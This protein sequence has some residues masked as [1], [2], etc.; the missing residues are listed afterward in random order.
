MLNMTRNPPSAMSN[1]RFADAVA[2]IAAELHGES[3][4]E[5]AG[6]DVQEH[7]PLAVVEEC[8]LYGDFTSRGRNGH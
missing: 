3:K 7:A 8:G 4:D 1:P 6:I 2:T 5:L